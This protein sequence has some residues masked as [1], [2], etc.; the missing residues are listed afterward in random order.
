MTATCTAGLPSVVSGFSSGNS[1]PALGPE[2]IWMVPC[3][4]GIAVA[5][6]AAGVAAGGAGDG[7]SLGA[8]AAAAAAWALMTV[9]LSF[10]AA[11]LLWVSVGAFASA[12]DP[13]AGVRSTMVFSNSAWL[14]VASASLTYLSLYLPISTTSLFWRKCFFTGWPLTSVPL[15]LPRSSR[16]ESL[17]IVMMMACSPLTARLSI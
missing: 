17:R 8:S 12:L 10:T 15:V 11:T 13:A 6:V 5:A 16:K 1:L 4:P 3:P 9:S 7:A 14:M 2:R